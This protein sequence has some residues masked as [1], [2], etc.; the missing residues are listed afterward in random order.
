[1]AHNFRV[2]QSSNEFGP[3]GEPRYFALCLEGDSR[4]GA[5]FV[6]PLVITAHYAFCYGLF[7][8]KKE[9][10]TLTYQ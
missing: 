3:N 6:S 1:M 2:I 10:G 9:R 7:H 4:S 8:Q 5:C